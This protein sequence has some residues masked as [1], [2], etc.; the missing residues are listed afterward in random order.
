MKRLIMKKIIIIFI[1]L[2]I[3]ANFKASA[4]A[5]EIQQLLL[6]VEKLSQLKKILSNMKKGYQ[7]LSTGYNT[8][9]DFEGKLS[10]SVLNKNDSVIIYKRAQYIDLLLNSDTVFGEKL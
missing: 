2:S 6:N 10:D 4:Q 3:G 8:I 5:N 1:I 7:I 9:E